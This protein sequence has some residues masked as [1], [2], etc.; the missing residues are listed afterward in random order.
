MKNVPVPVYCRPLVEKDPTMK[1]SPGLTGWGRDRRGLCPEAES[2]QVWGCGE[3]PV[4]GRQTSHLCPLS[5]GV[6]PV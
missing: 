4:T 5:C 1:V 2:R 3:G 6:L